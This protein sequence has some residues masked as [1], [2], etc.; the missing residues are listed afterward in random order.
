M[1]ASP[2]LQTIPVSVIIMTKDEEANLSKCLDGLR[3]LP[4]SNDWCVDADE[5][6]TL[7]V[8]LEIKEVVQHPRHK[9]YFVGYNYVFMDGTLGHGRVVHKFVLLKRHSARFPEH[10]NL[11]VAAAREV[12]LHFQPEISV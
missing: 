5:E 7:E 4:F 1:S 8:G 9:G 11:G 3:S 2:T 12:E 6:V 10:D